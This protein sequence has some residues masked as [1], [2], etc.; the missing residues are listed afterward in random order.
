M[1]AFNIQY[2]QTVNP[3]KHPPYV[4]KDY[5]SYL[6]WMEVGSHWCGSSPPHL[7]CGYISAQMTH[8]KG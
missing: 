8:T 3:V 7:K 2:R 4:A 6:F 1:F 5:V